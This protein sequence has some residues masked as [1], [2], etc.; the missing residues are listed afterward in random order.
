M[1]FL[2]PTQRL[3]HRLFFLVLAALLASLLSSSPLIARAADG[4]GFGKSKDLGEQFVDEDGF[5]YYELPDGSKIFQ[6]DDDRYE[7]DDGSEIEYGS[8]GECKPT[9]WNEEEEDSPSSKFIAISML[10]DE[11]DEVANEFSSILLTCA[12]NRLDV[13]I[14]VE[15][16]KSSG[17]KGSG[18][19]R[20]DKSKAKKFQYLAKA[21][22]ESVTLLDAQGFI[23][24]LLRSKTKVAFKIP[25]KSGTFVTGFP[26]GNLESFRASFAKAGC[27]F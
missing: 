3:S 8:W 23:K 16:A 19:Y 9:S 22:F 12:K 26:R 20:M 18:E 21:P 5:E 14:N 11:E 15:D 27:R 4:C 13:E 24:D 25:T 10:A 6:V 7:K 17:S 1:S 2:A